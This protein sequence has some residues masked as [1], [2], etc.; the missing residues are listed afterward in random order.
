MTVIATTHGECGVCRGRFKLRYDGY[1]RKH[2]DA[3]TL[4]TFNVEC[5]GSHTQPAPHVHACPCGARWDEHVHS[6]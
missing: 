3:R 1:L 2:V 5:E 6:P 4:G